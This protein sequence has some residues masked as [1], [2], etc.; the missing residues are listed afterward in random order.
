MVKHGA[1][2][3]GREVMARESLRILFVAPRIPFPPLY[4]DQVRAWNFLKYLSRRHTIVLVNPVFGSFGG[5]V[6]DRVRAVCYRWMPVKV[7]RVIRLANLY[8]YVF[9]RLPIQTILFCPPQLSKVVRNVVLCN[10]FELVH[11]ELVRCAPVLVEVEALPRVIDFVDALSLNMHC[12]SLH[13]RGLVRLIFQ[14]EARR[15][16][17]LERQAVYSSERQLIC[18]QQDKEA[19]GKFPTLHVVPNGVDLDDFAYSEYGRES[20]LITFTGHMSYAPN[21]DA[22]V[23]FARE[24]FPI[25][26]ARIP[27]ARFFVVGAH[28]PAMVRALGRVP[29]VVVTGSVARMQEYLWR[30]TVAVA[31]IRLGSG[32][33]NKVLEAMACGA[34]VVATSLASQGLEHAVDGEHL[35]VADDPDTMAQRT[36]DLLKDRGLRLQLARNARRLVEAEYTWERVVAKVEQVYRLAMGR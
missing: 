4:G 13:R 17:T 22:A 27:E 11:I 25:I 29:G 7:A 3:P 19:I 15:L 32:I 10:D 24:V 33:Q 20:N 34:P 5:E 36:V 16:A 26:R 28:P 12:R 1:S 18:S 35:I 8:K 30:T 6:Q 2:Y 23:Y 14:E 21:A 9:T 31:P